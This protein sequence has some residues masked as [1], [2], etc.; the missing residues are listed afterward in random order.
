MVILVSSLGELF[1][2]V[3]SIFRNFYFLWLLA[4][5]VQF[6]VGWDFIRR[7]FVS[8]KHRTADM[9]TLVA[10]G[11]LSAYSY[12]LVATLFPSIFHRAGLKP[13]VYFDTSA[14]II[15]LV[16][17][18]RYL[19]SRAKGRA[20]QAIKKLAALQAK[21]AR[22]IRNNQEIEIPAE[23]VKLGEIIVVRPGEK[24]AVD[25]IVIEG[26]ASVDESAISGES[27]PVFKKPGEEVIGATINRRG[28]FKFRATRVGSQTVMAQIIKLVQEAQATKAPVQRL[29]DKIA[30]Y[31]VP[32][33]MSVAVF[34]FILWF[35]FGPQPA[36]TRALLNFV[37]VMIIACPC[38]LGLA[39]PTAVMVGTGK[40]AESGILIRSGEILEKASQ[41]GTVIFDKTGTLTT[42]QPQVTEIIPGKNSPADLLE[43]AAGAE[44]GSEH[45]LAE[46]I[47]KAAREA[48][49]EPPE[50]EDFVAVEGL[51][52]KARVKG[53]KLL[54]GSERFL[55]AEGF[56]LSQ[57]VKDKIEA[58]EKQGQTVLGVAEQNGSEFY[59]LIAVSDK[60]KE[61]APAVISELKEMGLI[62]VLLTGDNFETGQAVGQ[63]LGLDRIIAE[64]LPQDKL[65]EVDRLQKEGKVVAM[66]GDGINDAPALVQADVGI[67]I[68]SATDIAIEAA[69]I[70]LIRSNL[71]KV[72]SALKIS[73]G[74]MAIIRQNLFW[75]FFYNIIGIPIAAG[76]LYPFF[77]LLLNP[78]IASLAMAFS[79]VSVV[80]NSLRLKRAKI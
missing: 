64:V 48:H 38:A 40:A 35:D 46:A 9:N 61:E 18:G 36:L 21:T 16:L 47:L 56:S 15:V 57:E 12:S 8:L 24:I 72:V 27:L 62:T 53:K 69:D 52:I 66:V 4:T 7:A 2:W 26:T 32:L 37:A 33:V 5:P 79:S 10:V 80:S 70:S 13:A 77:H 25:G 75:A 78:M 34:T 45:P 30:G 68:S 73:R 39:T 76:I 44:K 65:K 74:T 14:V 58:L 17:L 71:R 55:T 6:Y 11:T 28:Y 54:V 60:I 23:E 50:P 3:P 29:A 59:G 22:V 51:G 41:V 49:L 43:L 63:S 67:A 20:Y 19:E 1:P 31:F 42:G